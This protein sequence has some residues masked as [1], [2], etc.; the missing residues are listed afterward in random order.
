MRSG[1]NCTAANQWTTCESVMNSAL[2]VRVLLL[3]TLIGSMNRRKSG[4][5]RPQPRRHLR[6]G[7]RLPIS[8]SGSRVI[9]LGSP[10]RDPL[11]SPSRFLRP[12]FA[13][14]HRRCASS[15]ARSTGGEE[16]APSTHPPR[17]PETLIYS[18]SDGV[19]EWQNCVESGRRS[20]RSKSGRATAGFP[21]AQ[22]CLR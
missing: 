14:W 18:K 15:Y 4:N 17:V 19:V 10:V 13:W 8:Q 2:Q 1:A 20:R 6:P 3:V 22:R 16:V 12:F 7:A 9:L 21:I 5:H 11:K